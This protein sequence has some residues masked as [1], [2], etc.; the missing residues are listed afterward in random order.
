[1]YVCVRVQLIAYPLI[2]CAWRPTTC[3]A[4]R[5]TRP[6]ANANTVNWLSLNLLFASGHG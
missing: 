1:M 6:F 2:C 5:E 4:E 3:S